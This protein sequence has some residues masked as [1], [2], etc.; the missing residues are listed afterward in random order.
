MRPSGAG[1]GQ[2]AG[3]AACQPKHT[4]RA[5]HTD[6]SPTD[7][8]GKSELKAWPML[9]SAPCLCSAPGAASPGGTLPTPGQPAAPAR[10]A[11]TSGKKCQAVALAHVGADFFTNN[12][13]ALR[14]R[15]WPSPRSSP[16]GRRSKTASIAGQ[17]NHTADTKKPPEGGCFCGRRSAAAQRLL[18]NLRNAAICAAIA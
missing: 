18:R 12:P 9:A 1:N 15:R 7:E 2:A 10:L 6:Q 17:R 16:R 5:G 3:F 13:C 14:Q 4:P 8:I 11:G